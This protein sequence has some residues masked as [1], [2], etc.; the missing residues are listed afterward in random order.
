MFWLNGHCLWVQFI[1]VEASYSNENKLIAI[2]AHCKP[3]TQIR[4]FFACFSSHFTFKTQN[5]SQYKLTFVHL[6]YRHL[7]LSH[8]QRKGRVCF[9][10]NVQIMKL[11]RNPPILINWKKNGSRY[12]RWKF[13]DLPMKVK[14]IRLAFALLRI[15]CLENCVLY[16]E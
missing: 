12:L 3:I 15:I 2:T 5:R 1:N 14:Q 4:R 11:K 8:S 6:A 10:S 13:D 7:K 9:S 16:G